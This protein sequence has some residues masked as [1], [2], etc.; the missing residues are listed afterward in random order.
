MRLEQSGFLT[1]VNKE[2]DE[3]AQALK[4]AQKLD[5]KQRS[6]AAAM[7][8]SEPDAS[9]LQFKEYFEEHIPFTVEPGHQVKHKYTVEITRATFNQDCFKAFCKYEKRVHDKDDKSKQGYERF[10][11]Q[12]PLYDPRFPEEVKI[13][14]F[15]SHMDDH[16]DRKDEGLFPKAYGS[17]HMIHRIDGEVAIVGVLDFTD[18]CI[19]SVYLYYD[20]KW[21]FLNPGTLSALREIEYV[22]MLQKKQLAPESLHYYYMGLYY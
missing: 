6:Q 14:E 15:E 7:Q 5:S 18:T 11:C 2:V 20:P 3:A 1:V 17:Y 4:T 19:S 10:L 8:T 13:S 16:R 22:K 21:E 9:M 12:S